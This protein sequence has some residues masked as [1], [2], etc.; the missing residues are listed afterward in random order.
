[1]EPEIDIGRLGRA[2]ET[3]AIEQRRERGIGG[4]GQG[5]AGALL[6]D[7]RARGEKQLDEAEIDLG[8]FRQIN[9]D[10]AARLDSTKQ[11]LGEFAGV[12]HG[13][14]AG[15]FDYLDHVILTP[16][17]SSPNLWGTDLLLLFRGAF[18]DSPDANAFFVRGRCG[19]ADHD[20]A[21]IIAS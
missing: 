8:Q 6:L 1:V 5:E 19:T 3:G 4:L 16:A 17:K 15:R 13:N 14:G 18:R 10:I 21:D 9:V 12:S 11:T 20:G 2:E 7:M